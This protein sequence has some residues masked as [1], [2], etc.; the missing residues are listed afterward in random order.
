MARRRFA[1]LLAA[2]QKPTTQPWRERRLVIVLILF[3]FSIT[4]PF[5]QKEPPRGRAP[6]KL[7]GD[8]YYTVF[9]LA[10]KDAQPMQ[11]R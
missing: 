7:F 2:S 1:G 10:C 9:L 11:S 3:E 6:P 8:Y 4:P 5:T